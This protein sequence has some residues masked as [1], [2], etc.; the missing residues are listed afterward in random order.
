MSGVR[1]SS[2]WLRDLWCEKDSNSRVKPADYVIFRLP[3]LEE[4]L[5]QAHR[6]RLGCTVSGAMRPQ[7]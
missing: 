3:D 2:L 4:V 5:G 7:F 6:M 1:G